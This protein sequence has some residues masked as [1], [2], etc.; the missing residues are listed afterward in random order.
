MDRGPTY[1]VLG[2]GNQQPLNF[3]SSPNNK[4]AAVYT[5]EEEEERE[6]ELNSMFVFFPIESIL[7]GK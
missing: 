6:K 4:T 7:L 2:T 1:K 5:R 3:L